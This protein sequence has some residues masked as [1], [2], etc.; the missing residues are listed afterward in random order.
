[1]TRKNHV[2]CRI[3]LASFRTYTDLLISNRD[4][5]YHDPHS[6]T[7]GQI[8]RLLQGKIYSQVA[9]GWASLLQGVGRLSQIFVMVR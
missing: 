6:F 3:G 5:F 8:F 1:M 9:H 2:Y 7:N 4:E